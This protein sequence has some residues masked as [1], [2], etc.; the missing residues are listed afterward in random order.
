MAVNR[1]GGLYV[2]SSKLPPMYRE[3]VLEL[4]HEN[5]SQ[6]QIAQLTRTSLHFVQNVLRDYN[7]TNSPL[8]PTK[9][10]Y[11][12][13]T[14]TPD[15]VD[16]VEVEKLMKPSIYS[17]ELQERMV[18]DGVVHPL[19]VPRK[20]AI[21]ECIR[22]DL[23][24]T[25]KKL[26]VTP[27]ESTTANNVALKD[28]FLDQDS[29]LNPATLYFF[30][31]SSVLKTTA[32]RN[33][34]SSYVGQP[35][36]EFQRYASN[37]TYTINLLHSMKGVDYLNILDGPSNGHAMLL[38]F[39]EAVELQNYDVLEQG[40]TVIMDNCGFHQ[41]HFVEPLLT[42]MLAEYGLRLLFQPAYSPHLNPCE[43]YFHQI[44]CFLKRNQLLS[45]NHTEI[46]IYDARREITVENSCAYFR[47]CG[48][49]Q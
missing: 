23:L 13:P 27:L 33:F 29:D 10:A 25:H 31:E 26:S 8:Q 28:A 32:N 37:A 2:N 22:S 39:E 34:G 45:Q 12:R 36:F 43:L 24:M 5:F 15:V 44:K 17:G 47:H 30:D 49:L 4:H 7:V 35:A 11:P 19:D 42:D 1:R 16:Y 6:R 40:D 20:A 48:Y 9:S 41:G 38:F 14:M 46:A 21:T 18:L 3:R